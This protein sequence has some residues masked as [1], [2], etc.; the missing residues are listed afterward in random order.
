MM[1]TRPLLRAGLQALTALAA[2]FGAATCGAR[3]QSDTVTI[4]ASYTTV[5]DRVRPDPR[6]DVRS[7]HS[8]ELR[9]SGVRRVDESWQSR[10]GRFGR[11]S[12][13]V[14]QLG[15]G[16]E[17]GTGAWRV[18]PNNRIQR[19]INYTQS[20][21]TLTITVDRDDRC[22]LDVSSALKPGFSEF[23]FRRQSTGDWGYF[24]NRRAND[25]SCEVAR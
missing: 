20:V 24:V 15:G 11:E 12:H 21:T 2:T 19:K 22:R 9:L 4:R 7:R 5:M 14:K 8:L 10:S 3:A 17:E 6:S 1:K 25:L 16:D 23:R 13:R 18:L